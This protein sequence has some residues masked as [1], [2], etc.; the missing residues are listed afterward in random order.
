MGDI[1]RHLLATTTRPAVDVHEW[2][3]VTDWLARRYH[4]K[5]FAHMPPLRGLSL[6]VWRGF[7]ARHPCALAASPRPEHRELKARFD[8]EAAAACIAAVRRVHRP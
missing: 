2:I 4:M 8:A 6:G 5:P 3:R 7:H 1:E